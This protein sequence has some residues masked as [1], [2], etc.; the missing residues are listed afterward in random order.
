MKRNH[1]N[2]SILL[3]HVLIVGFSVIGSHAKLLDPIYQ[4]PPDSPNP[5]ECW[6]DGDV[7]SEANIAAMFQ[8]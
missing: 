8:W 2:N 4:E 6:K 3:V 7:A 5:E 1:L